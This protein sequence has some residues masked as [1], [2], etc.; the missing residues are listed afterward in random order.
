MASSHSDRHSIPRLA[1]P[2]QPLIL[3]FMLR[4]SAYTL[5]TPSLLCN[6]DSRLAIIIV[7]QIIIIIIIAMSRSTSSPS[8]SCSRFPRARPCLAQSQ[9]SCAPR[10]LA[11]SRRVTR[12]AERST[13]RPVIVS[14]STCTTIDQHRTTPPSNSAHQLAIRTGLHRVYRDHP[15]TANALAAK[16]PA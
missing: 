10:L 12:V 8:A 3:A 4:L 14:S 7:R 2:L 16:G 9:P 13:I 15:R 5:Y 6:I 11:M 1:H